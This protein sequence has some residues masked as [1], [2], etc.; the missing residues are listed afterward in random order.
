[1]VTDSET[2]AIV[3]QTSHD[4]F[5]DAP[6]TR[7][8]A[9]L[10][11]FGL[12]TPEEMG[13]SG[14]RPV[15][16]CAIA[17]EAG[18]AYSPSSWAESA[19]AAGALSALP[20]RHVE[21]DAVLSGETTAS[22]CTGRIEADSSSGSRVSGVFPFSAGLP[23]RVVVVTDEDGDTG[24]VVDGEDGISIEEQ[25]G[26]LDTTR[27]LHCLRLSEAETAPLGG[28]PLAW[29]TTTAQILSCADTVGALSTAI[30]VVTNHLIERQA[31]GTSLA[32]FQAIQHRLVDLEILH[33]SAQALLYRAAEAIELKTDASLADATHI[34]LSAR[35]I[36]ALEDC[37]QL[38]G[39]M[40]F[41][42][43]FG[44]HHALRRALTNSAAVRTR[45][46]SG[47]RLANSRGWR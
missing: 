22:F 1:V 34:F 17:E 6:T 12:F 33:V 19:I 5:A 23:A 14:W 16:A 36:P 24:A 40:G 37:V 43:E 47:A 41:T 31:F 4:V 38:A 8:M 27:S 2:L 29:L 11:W 35:A 9:D 39:G 30:K 46:L 20:A 42:W 28:S 18:A 7:T 15:E 10:G 45:R 26:C 21:V 32:S 3:R 25:S 44:I 13:G